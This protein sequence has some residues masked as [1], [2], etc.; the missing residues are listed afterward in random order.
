MYGQ[1]MYYP[2]YNPG[3]G[4]YVGDPNQPGGQPP[5]GFQPQPVHSGQNPVPVSQPVYANPQTQ[6]QQR[7]G[8]D[9]PANHRRSPKSPPVQKEKTQ[10][11]KRIMKRPEEKTEATSEVLPVVEPAVEQPVIEKTEGM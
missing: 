6:V 10:P 9:S 4:N 5:Q 8:R 7:R 11:E 3:Y 2:Y 1:P